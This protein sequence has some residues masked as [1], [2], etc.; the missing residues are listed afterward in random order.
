MRTL[1]HDWVDRP[2][3]CISHLFRDVRVFWLRAQESEIAFCRRHRSNIRLSSQGYKVCSWFLR[4]G[5]KRLYTIKCLLIL[6]RDLLL[7]IRR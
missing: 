5:Q 4:F 6:S 2:G 3:G 7:L 1:D